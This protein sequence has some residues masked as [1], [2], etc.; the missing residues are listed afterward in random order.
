MRTVALRRGLA[1]TSRRISLFITG[2]RGRSSVVADSGFAAL[3]GSAEHIAVERG[4]SEFRSGRPIL[5]A[6]TGRTELVMPVDGMDDA[7]L[8]SFRQVCAPAA[9]Y[10]AVTAMRACAL[11]LAASGP[12]GLAIGD[13]ESAAAILAL[14]A[15]ADP[16]RVPA[17]LPPSAAAAAA[18]D[19]AK[20][21]HRL[22]ALLMAD[23]GTARKSAGKLS[24]VEVAAEAV[25]QLRHAAN[26]S[27]GVVAESN[28]PLSGGLATRFVVFR[29]GIGGSS[30][31]VIIGRPD[32]ARPVPVRLHS[33]CLTGDVFGSRRCD[34]GDQLRLAVGRI[35]QEGGGIIL[36]LEQEGRGV[37]LANKMRAYALQDAGLDTIDANA[38]LGFDDDER[39]Y[40]VAGDML[41]LLGCK[42]VRL[43]TNN[44]A[45]LDG[46]AQAGIEI[47]GR[48]PLH[49]P[50]NADNR[51]YLTAKAMRAGH[52]LDHL[53][54]ALT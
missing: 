5:I 54:G 10:L 36:Y 43:L 38:T 3:F 37:G 33:S 32:L 19:L 31:A 52:K 17:L 21:A 45:K 8:A 29:D 1:G 42:Q 2:V 48:V 41:R 14:A 25:G 30:V 53:L 51:R 27:L 34:C 40:G 46:L 39:G 9:P 20:L 16:K 6:K 50:V 24:L 12:V 4:L 28:V 49:G 26:A 18:I 11:G 23:G 22:P 13:E 47:V 7:R 35:D 44:P 15:D